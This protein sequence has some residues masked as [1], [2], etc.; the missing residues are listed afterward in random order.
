MN[1]EELKKLQLIREHL[2]DLHDRWQNSPDSDHH[3]MSEGYVGVTL[4]YPNW[5]E[6]GANK[7]DYTSAMPEI[8]VQV[9]SYLF[10]P[11]RMHDFGSLDEALKEVLTWNT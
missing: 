10:G 7:K 11:H 3:K 2:A 9:Y 6:G 8:T 5:F 1:D 4:N